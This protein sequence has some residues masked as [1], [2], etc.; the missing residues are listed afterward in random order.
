MFPAVPPAHR[1]FNRFWLLYSS[2]IH[3]RHLPVDRAKS[4]PSVARDAL[5]EL[6]DEWRAETR[7]AYMY[8]H[9]LESLA[10]TGAHGCRRLR[11]GTDWRGVAAN[12]V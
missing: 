11:L 5:V 8:A 7:R 2:G 9:Q 6:C 4:E 10:A 3:G 12:R 1:L